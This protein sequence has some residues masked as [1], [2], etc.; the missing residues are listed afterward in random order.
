MSNKLQISELRLLCLVHRY[1][2]YVENAPVISDR[3]YDF[4]ER[5]LITLLAK[6]PSLSDAGEYSQFCPSKNVGSSLISS[7]PS[8]IKT[9]CSHV[10]A[11]KVQR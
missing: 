5:S 3:D 9:L 4:L 11:K 2:Y 7:Y 8:N 6:E 1:L 10:I